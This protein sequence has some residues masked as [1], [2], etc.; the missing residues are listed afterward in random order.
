MRKESEKRDSLWQSA[1]QSP[2]K[3][4]SGNMPVKVAVVLGLCLSTVAAIAVWQRE[5]ETLA[6]ELRESTEN[7]RS[8]LQEQIDG[9]SDLTGGNF[10]AGEL[11]KATLPGQVLEN[12]NIYLYQE[13]VDGEFEPL[14]F[15]EFNAH[16]L[17]VDRLD[18]PKLSG[19]GWLCPEFS[20]PSS[21][22][23]GQ[24]FRQLRQTQTTGKPCQRTLSV[25]DRQWFLLLLPTSAYLAPYKYWQSWGIFLGGSI[26]T[27]LLATYLLVSGRYTKQVE[28]LVEER[29]I[30][31]QQLQKALEELQE[32][33]GMLVHSEK[34]SSLGQMVAGIA[35]EINNPVNFISGNISCTKEYVQDLLKLIEVYQSH[36]P[37]PDPDIEE[38]SSEIDLD[39]LAEDLP[40]ILN[41]MQV[42]VNRI[43]Q[44][45]L[46]MRNFS[47][48]DR[49][50]MQA[51]N[52]HEGIDSTL[53]I[54]NNRLTAKAGIY[55]IKLIKT[56]GELP[57]VECNAG[58]LNQVFMNIVANAIDAIESYDKQRSQEEKKANPSWIAIQTSVG[59]ASDIRGGYDYVTV[60]IADNGPGI[61]ADIQKKIF[62]PF[63]TTKPVGKGT[64]LGMSIAYK[65]V[66]EGH[67]GTIRCRSSV[68]QGTEFT[69]NLPIRQISTNQK[70]N[71]ME[72]CVA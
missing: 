43:S 60:T 3:K 66:V 47:R 57:L 26:L 34:M 21:S 35:H 63:F 2:K 45:V 18:P 55:G 41:S 61:P 42:G 17:I 7:L 19:R 72:I 14:A 37:N 6:I 48:L 8:A 68:G 27:S 54:L 46:S 30:K 67:G 4:A 36:Y 62:D 10:S 22:S 65:I 51:V 9:N 52:L 23:T 24:A 44:I 58:Q 39:F 16:T 25:G 15:Y 31:A 33:Q 13:S 49:A 71:L 32:T 50:E 29:T 1:S 28:E 20:V 59:N 38:F 70:P 11:L 40:K 64:G 5:R 69:I 53:L 12:L 56:Y